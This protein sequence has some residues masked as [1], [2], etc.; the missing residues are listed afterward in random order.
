M[1]FAAWQTQTLPTKEGKKEVGGPN[2]IRGYIASFCFFASGGRPTGNRSW[3]G[4]V[5]A[6]KD[7][8]GL[9]QIQAGEGGEGGEEHTCIFCTIL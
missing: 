7:G 2:E 1:T 8:R 9:R 4:G 5:T 6:L 3:K